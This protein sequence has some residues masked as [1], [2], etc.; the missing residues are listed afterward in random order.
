MENEENYKKM[1]NVKTIFINSL[2]TLTKFIKSLIGEKENGKD[3]ARMK[4][5]SIYV[6][7]LL[8]EMN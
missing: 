6:F 7:L 8:I 5:N 1:L 2:F 4:T 3:K